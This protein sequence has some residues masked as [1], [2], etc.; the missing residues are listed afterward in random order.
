MRK[1]QRKKV[2]FIN[3]VNVGKKHFLQLWDGYRSPKVEQPTSEYCKTTKEIQEKIRRHDRKSDRVWKLLNAN[4]P[5][6]PPEKVDLSMFVKEPNVEIR[7]EYIRKVGLERI[8]PYL[9]AQELHS[10]KKT[11]KE[12]VVNGERSILVRG[13]NPAQ[14][15]QGDVCI[16]YTEDPNYDMSQISY[17]MYSGEER[18][19]EDKLYLINLGA[20]HS[21]PIE[22]KALK[23]QNPS[24]EGIWHLE[25]VG[26]EVTTCREAH[27]WRMYGDV[28]KEWN[29]IILT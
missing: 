12:V 1:E 13:G 9:N 10:E 17:D 8:L 23:M 20:L 16:D 26:D 15:Q 4:I 22:V 25:Y 29:P 2:Y 27:N 21:N 6:I 3:G 7:K 11:L 19:I 14:I 18:V 24:V 28:N 5:V